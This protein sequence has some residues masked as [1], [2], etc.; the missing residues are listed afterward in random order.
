MGFL[1]SFFFETLSIRKKRKRIEKQ[2]ISHSLLTPVNNA[3][4]LF[5]QNIQMFTVFVENIIKSDSS[6]REYIL[7]C[8]RGNYNKN[9]LFYNIR[10]TN[11][12]C[13]KKN[14][15]HHRNTIAIMIDTKNIA[16]SI[17]CRDTDYDNTIIN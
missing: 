6:H 13:P 1:M 15:H 3:S 17:R 5:D 12:Y 10:G 8:L 2:N 7:S 11:R 4:D 14:A 9:I 16:Y